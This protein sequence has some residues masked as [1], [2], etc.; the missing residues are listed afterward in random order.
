M[1][2]DFNSGKFVFYRSLNNYN[3]YDNL[4]KNENYFYNNFLFPT[5]NK[6]GLIVKFDY[7]FSIG[8]DLS[9]NYKQI[10]INSIVFNNYFKT[11][12]YFLFN[13]NIFNIYIEPVFYFMEKYNYYFYDLNGYVRLSLYNFIFEFLYK[14]TSEEA[15]NY[16]K[17]NKVLSITF[18]NFSEKKKGGKFNFIKNPYKINLV[19]YFEQ[20]YFELYSIMNFYKILEL[21]VNSKINKKVLNDYEFKIKLLFPYLKNIS[22][23]N[24]LN[25]DLKNHYYYIFYFLYKNDF[26]KVSTKIY[27]NTFLNNKM[28]ILDKVVANDFD[29]EYVYPES[30]GFNLLL[31]FYID[32][33]ENY[34]TKNYN[35]K[36]FNHKRIIYFKLNYSF[37]DNKMNSKY[38]IGMNFQ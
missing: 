2:K 3:F 6:I 28:L 22:I 5:S 17:Y 26:I 35:N 10:E 11:C 21:E 33:I 12:F 13:K 24:T 15:I 30:V 29:I 27:K 19:Y 20:N 1:F 38:E 16:F 34:F 36:N 14:D 23:K 8:M 25:F 32:K 7:P 4:L 9:N 37:F 31:G 18:D